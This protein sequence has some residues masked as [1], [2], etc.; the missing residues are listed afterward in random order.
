MDFN[1]PL[2]TIILA[3]LSLIL[4]VVLIFL[5]RHILRQK[6]II[7]K[8]LEKIQ[9]CEPITT[10]KFY[11]ESRRS[12]KPADI[13]HYFNFALN[14][15]QE[16]FKK[17]T[18]TTHLNLDKDLP[19]SGKIAALRHLYLSAEK[20]VFDDRGIT[21]A[22]WSTLERRLAP[23]VQWTDQ[24]ASQSEKAISELQRILRTKDDEIKRHLAKNAHL[25]K[26]LENL[27]NEQHSLEH[28]NAKNSALIDHLQEALEKLKRVK[29]ESDH[30]ERVV[31]SSPLNEDYINQFGSSKSEYSQNLNALLYEIKNTPPAISPAQQKRIENQV[32]MLEIELLKSDRYVNDLKQQLKE[33]KQQIT[34]FALMRNDGYPIADINSLYE[35]L[36]QKIS[37]E[38]NED[39]DT[40]IAEIKNLEQSNQLQHRTISHLE[41][42]ISTIKESINSE[43]SDAVN[44]EK[45]KEIQRLERLVKECQGC[46][47]IL[48]EEVDNLYARLQEQAAQ[49]NKM[50]P[51]KGD[52]SDE[53]LHSNNLAEVEMLVQELQKTSTNYQHVYAINA[54]L[55]DFLHCQDF[56]ALT[57]LLQNFIEKFNL[58]A[59]F[60]IDCKAGKKEFIP[61]HFI[62]TQ[63]TLTLKSL[64]TQDTLAHI[65]NGTLFNYPNIRVLRNHDELHPPAE[66]L[67]TNF[68]MVIAAAN[69]RLND[70]IHDFLSEQKDESDV[71]VDAQIKDML[72]NLNIR[73]AFQ[74]DENRK[75]FEHF[76]GEL[77]RAY[78]LLEL[79]G[80]GAVILDN[81]VNEFELRVSLLLE[82]GDAI[83]KEISLLVDKI[84]QD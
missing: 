82:S 28:I 37:P 24:S 31:Y 39:P 68:Q 40:I 64:D 46:I 1:A 14:D 13:P 63:D 7:K 23:I 27:R 70:L 9:N 69:E 84:N 75:T 83:D 67:D 20:E 76:I 5:I 52:L 33:A 29:P 80:P 26:R 77:R 45:E 11:D 17:F 78:G 15:A 48:E 59:G 53:E 47:I 18:G 51:E 34:N 81:A 10:E 66:M 41:N 73:Y 35:E 72:N 6:K 79:T 74:V 4:I 32:N 3:E 21:H 25:L 19:F 16:R 2:S 62:S 50:L 22:G 61:E 38:N 55:L 30:Q 58:P 42:E 49:L 12:E 71:P 44:I 57:N 56:E 43:D 60:Y 36:M 8:L 54:T 65:E